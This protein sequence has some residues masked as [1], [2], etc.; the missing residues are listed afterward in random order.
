MDIKGAGAI[1]DDTTAV[2]LR[3]LGLK[4]EQ[5]GLERDIYQIIIL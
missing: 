2:T 4:Y 5:A 3:V 1:F